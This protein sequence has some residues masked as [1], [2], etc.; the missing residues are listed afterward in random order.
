[1]C[2][3]ESLQTI[4]RLRLLPHHIQHR[5]HQFGT[6]SVMSLSPIVSGTALSEH[7]IVRSEDLAEWSGTDRVHG[8]GFEIDENGTGY[9]FA[10]GRLIVVNVDAFELEV[11]VAVVGAGGVDAV[12]VGDDLPELEGN[13]KNY[14]PCWQIG[15]LNTKKLSKIEKFSENLSII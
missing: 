5:I 3:L 12:L 8:A 4:T 14:I 13:N 11:G 10:A 7:K 15:A 1:M 6:F 9:V 2:Q